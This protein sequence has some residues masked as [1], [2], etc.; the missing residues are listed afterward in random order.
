MKNLYR[1]DYMVQTRRL[2]DY[3]NIRKFNIR[4]IKMS[5]I[6]NYQ[7]QNTRSLSAIKTQQTASTPECS[8]DSRKL[9]EDDLKDLYTGIIQELERVTKSSELQEIATYYFDVRGKGFRP[10]LTILMAKAVNYHINKDKSKLLM[11]QKHL[12]MIS[13][14]VHVATLMHDDVVDEEKTRRGR[15]SINILWDPKKVT[16]AG[17]FVWM[18]AVMMT[19]RLKNDDVTMLIS[20]LV[21][22]IVQG[23]LL[24]LG[25]GE[26]ENEGFKNYMMK[27]H[28]KTA[29]PFAYTMKSTAL[30]TGATEDVCEMALQYGRNLGIAFQLVDDVLDL[31]ADL[32]EGLTTAPVLFACEQFPELNMIA[33]RG[34]KEPGDV[35]RT[36][37]LVMCSQ[38]V[39]QTQ[40]LARKH[41][42]E[43]AKQVSLLAE[44]PYKKALQVLTEFVINRVK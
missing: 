43:A 13:E 4:S 18:V 1:V 25:I 16:L 31:P 37:E 21:L 27:T 30:L 10:M 12:A 19:S 20:E 11:S 8:V 24:Q 34:F 42:N 41:G 7:L 44:S 36:A 29:N 17:E 38:G 23:E 5:H 15:P 40:F 6:V 2:S 33:K 39:E 22:N 28:L 35:E 3:V 14:M 32:K 9:I 26:T